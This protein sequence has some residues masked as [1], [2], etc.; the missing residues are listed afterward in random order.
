MPRAFIVR[1]GL[2]LFLVLLT[3]TACSGTAEQVSSSSN[4]AW[5]TPTIVMLSPFPTPT[6]QPTVT[7]IPEWTQTPVR[8]ER[9]IVTPSPQSAP[10]ATSSSN[11]VALTSPPIIPRIDGTLAT[12]LREIYMRGRMLGDRPGVFI[13]V[14][15]SITESQSF[16]VEF[17][18][19]SESLGAFQNLLSTIDYFRNTN[20][21]LDSN[22]WCEASNSFTRSSLAATPGWTAA[23]AL[24]PFEPA[25]PDCPEP[26]NT[27]LRCEIVLMRPSLALIM[28]GTNDVPRSEPEAYRQ[29]L[30][31]IVS[32]VES[33]GV[34]PVLST[35]PPRFAGT[36]P[37]TID[38]YNQIIREIA[39]SR[40]IPL[41]NYW[42]ALQGPEMVN[43]GMDKDGIHPN[44][45]L[46]DHAADLTTQG[47]RYGYN[48]RNLTAIQVLDK[49]KRIIIDNGA[50]DSP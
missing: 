9:D 11:S 20:L 23:D 22:G 12:R 30:T 37:A 8:V 13:K 36:N 3:S 4:G 29:N 35:I 2:L 5:P 14:G 50:P 27:P 40:Q 47:L 7:R 46:G 16:L 32:E 42:L 18:C 34:I 24:S 19:K 33:G 10:K 39:E 28:F 1:S 44:V 43:Q 15:D 31:Q 21:S 25:R 48:Q 49:L 41:W 38:Q 17:G 6:R 45:Y 26:Y